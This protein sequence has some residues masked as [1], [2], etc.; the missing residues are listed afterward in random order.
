MYLDADNTHILIHK[1]RSVTKVTMNSKKWVNLAESNLYVKSSQLR[2]VRITTCTFMTL[3][4]MRDIFTDS[5][6][7]SPIFAR[8]TYIFVSWHFAQ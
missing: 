7:E 5:D 8:L 2:R 4:L 1:L 6:G 3:T